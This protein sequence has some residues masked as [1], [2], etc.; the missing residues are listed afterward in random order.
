MAKASIRDRMEKLDRDQRFL[1]WFV[2]QRFLATLTLEELETWASG[3]GLPNPVP[4]GP[5]SLD[6]MDRKSLS[7]L[8]EEN[9]LI[10]GGRSKEEHEFYADNG[11]WPERRG[12][13]LY[14][15]EDGQLQIEWRSQAQEEEVVAKTASERQGT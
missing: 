8:W 13:L 7:R 2:L 12:R 11:F 4:N 6:T 15:L 5:S 1:D 10:F 14:F 9:E 3:G